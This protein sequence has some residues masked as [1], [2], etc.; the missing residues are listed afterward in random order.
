M[1]LN[2]PPEA[3]NVITERLRVTPFCL[4]AMTFGEDWGWDRALAESETIVARFL[5]RGGN[6]VDT[7]N[8]S[9]TD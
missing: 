4:G 2:G 5:E 6:C 7:A 1:C 3:K 9:A 8:V